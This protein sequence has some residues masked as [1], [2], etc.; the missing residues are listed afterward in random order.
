[1]VCP[2]RE[3]SQSRHPS[4]TLLEE[5]LDRRG[6]LMARQGGQRAP[7]LT[8]GQACLPPW[9]CDGLGVGP[10]ALSPLT[11][12]WRSPKGLALPPTASKSGHLLRPIQTAQASLFKPGQTRPSVLPWEEASCLPPPHVGALWVGSGRAQ[13]GNSGRRLA[14]PHLAAA[15]PWSQLSQ[16]VADLRE[17]AE[18]MFQGQH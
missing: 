3:T 7:P 1:M 6:G 12:A 9:S 8:Q 13:L 16:G 18:P 14:N 15:S 4:L 5:F 10:R 11:P 2:P 17:Q